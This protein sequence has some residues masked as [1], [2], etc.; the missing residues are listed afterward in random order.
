MLAAIL[1]AATEGDSVGDLVTSP[2]GGLGIVSAILSLL[3]A[4]RWLIK[5]DRDFN[6]YYKADNETLR[7]TL[8][9]ERQA[10]MGEVRALREE[11]NRHIES[12]RSEN[13][14]VITALRLEHAR[15]IEQIRS[16]LV[17]E[18]DRALVKMRE[19]ISELE[20]IIERRHGSG[21]NPSGENRRIG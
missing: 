19:R 16:E 20:Q 4:I 11:H 8:A 21:E 17:A 13:N 10:R 12:I 9:D 15:E 7:A 5:M 3:A 14:R 1:S 2:V 18:R 6:A